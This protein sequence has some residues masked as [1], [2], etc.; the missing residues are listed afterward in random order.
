MAINADWIDSWAD[1]YEKNPG[2]DDAVLT[3]VGARVRRREAYDRADLLEVGRW[4]SARVLPTLDSNTDAMIDDR[5]CRRHTTNSSTRPPRPAS[6]RRRFTRN[7]PNLKA[8]NRS[9]VRATYLVGHHARRHITS[10]VIVDRGNDLFALL[11]A[12][13]IAVIG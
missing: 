5:S 2:Y 13:H 9:D 1:L 7:S 8:R 3:E 10:L 11:F 6:C 12:D 4:K